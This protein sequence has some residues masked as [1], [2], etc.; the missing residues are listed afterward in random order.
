VVLLTDLEEIAASP[1][2]KARQ[3]A[4]LSTLVRVPKFVL[5]CDWKSGSDSQLLPKLL[6]GFGK[7]RRFAVRSSANVE[8][9]SESSY[10]GMFESVL[11]VD[12]HGVSA[13]LDAVSSSATSERVAK[14]RNAR[15][16]S[17]SQ[18]SMG[19][20]VQEMIAST[21]SGVALSISG[22]NTAEMVI[23]AVYGLGELLV[24]GV[25]QPDRYYVDRESLVVTSEVLGFQNE[26]LCMRER[27]G[28]E[29]KLVPGPDRRTRKL[30]G[31]ELR[32]VV[33]LVSAI[34]GAMET[35]AV[36]VE[37]AFEGS[38]LYCLQARPLV[39]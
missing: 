23:E 20:I 25:V 32:E 12:L 1:Y 15:S 35:K 21:V 31:E 17:K 34:E 26:M 16:E 10:A 13:A 18:I 3:L 14:Y 28:V 38:R 36:D 22:T 2:G 19:I 9:S 24:G 11:G 8:D 39:G 33:G 5:V 37:W 29:R 27:G 30:L 4:L 6:Q 7:H